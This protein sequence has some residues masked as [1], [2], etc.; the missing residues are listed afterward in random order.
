VFHDGKL[1][2]TLYVTDDNDFLPDVA[3]PNH[4]YVFGFT[5]EDL[6]GFK[7][8]LLSAVPEPASWMMMIGGFGL[9]GAA[10][11]RKRRQSVS[12]HYA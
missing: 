9:V 12:V 3:G 6:P 5:D 2:H 8:Q 11:R 4:F 7:A 10:L 1:F